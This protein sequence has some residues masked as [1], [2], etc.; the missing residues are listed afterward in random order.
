MIRWCKM[1]SFVFVICL[2][3][4]LNAQ[5]RFF[6]S[7]AY[8]VSFPVGEQFK[9]YVSKASTRGVAG[10]VM[11]NISTNIRVGLQFSYNDFYKKKDRSVY[12]LADGSHISAVL[13]NTLQLT[14]VLLKGEYSFIP[15]GR[16]QPFAGVGA[17]V[18]FINFEQYV[19]EFPYRKTFTKSAFAGSVG[20]VIPFKKNGHSGFK[21]A[22]D[23]VI[24]P[25]NEEGINRVDSWNLQAGVVIPLR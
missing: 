16:V 23:Y 10:S 15:G 12:T 6:G 9:D 7:L 3:S 14:P 20:I 13:S 18:A 19:G 8:N 17:G 1:T 22:S 21:L 25:F 11:Y 2:V 24:S 4:K 5:Q